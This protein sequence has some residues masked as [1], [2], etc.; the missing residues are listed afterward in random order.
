MSGSKDE[1]PEWSSLVELLRDRATALPDSPLFAFLGDGADGP[2]MTYTRGDLD[3]RARALAVEL[4][5]LGY[6]GK[7]R[8]CSTRRG[9]SLSP[10]FSAVCMPA[11]WRCPPTRH[12]SIGR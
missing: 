4:R 2:T 8:R 10:R 3:A 9:W 7:R 1:R 5:V 12:G 11:S 6:E